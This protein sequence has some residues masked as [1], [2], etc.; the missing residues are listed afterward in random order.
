MTQDEHCR[1]DVDEEVVDPRHAMLKEPIVG[2]EVV[3]Y[4]EGKGNGA[5]LPKPLPSPKE[6]SDAQ[7]RIHDITHMPYDPGCAIC[8]SCRRPN[9]HH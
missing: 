3:T 6:M 9:D 5:I 1:G 2:H 7:R 4:E 8:V